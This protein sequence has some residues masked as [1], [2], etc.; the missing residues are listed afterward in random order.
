MMCCSKLMAI[1][2]AIFLNLKW[3]LHR[4]KRGKTTVEKDCSSFSLVF[5]WSFAV[6]CWIFFQP[7]KEVQSFSAVVLPREKINNIN[8]TL[9]S[10]QG[11]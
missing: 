5:C 3:P 2:I 4:K 10:S 6:L 7:I 11:D 8:P 9:I 1:S